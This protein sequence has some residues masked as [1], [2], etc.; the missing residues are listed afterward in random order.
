MTWQSFSRGLL[1]SAR[2][3]SS[4][5]TP[6]LRRLPVLCLLQGWIFWEVETKR[7]WNSQVDF[8]GREKTRERAKLQHPCP[9]RWFINNPTSWLV[10]DHDTPFSGVSWF[11]NCYE[12]GFS[13]HSKVV[14]WAQHIECLESMFQDQLSEQSSLYRR[15][16]QCQVMDTQGSYYSWYIKNI[17]FVALIIL[18]YMINMTML[19]LSKGPLR[20][21]CLLSQSQKSP[22]WSGGK[23]I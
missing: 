7:F 15:K 16:N 3:P 23:I 1:V 12:K 21:A 20:Q 10:N 18:V 19:S 17:C 22:S 6:Y 8:S 13:G 11:S 9:L 5:P 14:F 4:L 2:D